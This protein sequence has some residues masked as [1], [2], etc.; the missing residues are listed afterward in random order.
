M[1]LGSHAQ[2]SGGHQ[3]RLLYSEFTKRGIVVWYDQMKDTTVDVRAKGMVKGVV[4]H[5]MLEIHQQE[6]K[7][8]QE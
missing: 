3:T 2:G 5:Y 8:H 7:I 4:E 1:F 6:L